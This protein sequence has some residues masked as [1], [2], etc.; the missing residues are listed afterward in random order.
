MAESP[1]HTVADDGVAH[2]LAD[3]QAD[4]GCEGVGRAAR[5]G[6]QVHD[7]GAATHPP[8][9][10]HGATE[11]VAVTQPLVGGEHGAPFSRPGGPGVRARSDREA[12]AALA[13]ARGDDGA[14]G[15]GAH[16]QTE[17][18]HLV[19]AAVVRLVGPLAHDCISSGVDCWVWWSRRLVGTGAARV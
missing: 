15:T 17:T 10:L 12:L 9:R 14:P 5:R 6:V 7:E 4:P 19:P 16:A 1:L 13:A 11:R 8:A 2:D 18:V 3:H